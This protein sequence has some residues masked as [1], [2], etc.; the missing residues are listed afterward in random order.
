MSILTQGNG[1]TDDLIAATRAVM[2][3]EK[4]KMDPVD[5]KELEGSHAERDDKDI[6]NDGDSDKSDQYLHKK[7]KAIKKSMKKDDQEGNDDAIKVNPKGEKD[8]E[9][10]E[11]YGAHQ[12]AIAHAKKDGVNTKKPGLMQPYSDHHMKKRGYTHRV[13]GTYKKGKDY[14]NSGTALKSLGE[15][16]SPFTED[17]LAHFNSVM[18]KQ[19]ADKDPIDGNLPANDPGATKT[20]GP[21]KK[22]LADKKK[23]PMVKQTAKPP[24]Q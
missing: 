1:L 14:T 22:Q 24:G 20:D 8:D 18:E 11:D 4:K 19:M 7:R 6:D 15:D 21:H 5:A 10:K 9:M 23:D 2:M 17:E 12:D 13:G 3:G 16:D